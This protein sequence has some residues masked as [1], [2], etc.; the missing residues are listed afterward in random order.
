MR[1]VADKSY[2]RGAVVGLT[3]AELF[4]L[5]SFM[6]ITALLLAE[7]Q[8]P[9]KAAADAEQPVPGVSDAVARAALEIEV[10]QLTSESENLARRL[11]DSEARRKDAQDR[12]QQL[13]RTLAQERQRRRQAEE[14]ADEAVAAAR[15][16]RADAEGAEATR[17]KATAHASALEEALTAAEEA[18]EA[19]K[20]QAQASSAEAEEAETAKQQAEAEARTAQ[21]AAQAA[22][23]QAEADRKKLVKMQGERTG[24]TKR[25]GSRR[26]K[27]INPPCWYRAVSQ[28][29]GTIREKP[30]YLLDI[31]IHDR[32]I[33]LGRRTPPP[34]GP[35]DEKGSYASEFQQVGAHRLPYGK[36][37]TDAE[38]RGALTEIKRKGKEAKIRSY[39]C[40]SYGQVWDQTGSTSK[41]RWRNAH[42]S[43]VQQY[44]GTYV[45]QDPRSSPWPH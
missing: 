10:D 43:L 6:L 22:E 16:A 38:V 41:Q 28:G 17:E 7:A 37:L 27:G 33:V 23:R 42:E 32:H 14:D 30:L 13:A 1:R 15:A 20:A 5:T 40:I 29:D 26:Q 44:L 8:L 12:Y 4:M 21:E 31:A 9:R 36:R 18:A 25:T 11:T 2:R 3:T 39:P 35:D 24:T 45:V 19:A 34:G